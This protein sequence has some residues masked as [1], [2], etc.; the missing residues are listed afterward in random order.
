[1]NSYIPEPEIEPS[2][3]LNFMIKRW[4]EIFESDDPQIP[5]FLQA[6]AYAGLSTDEELTTQYTALF[7]SQQLPPLEVIRRSIEIFQ[8]ALRHDPDTKSSTLISEE[9][10]DPDVK[11]SRQVLLL[12]LY[13]GKIM[14][15][16]EDYRFHRVFEMLGWI[17]LQWDNEGL[18]AFDAVRTTYRNDPENL[19]RKGRDILRDR[20]ER[21]ISG[22]ARS[23]SE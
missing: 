12:T 23:E 4:N 15:E 21:G 13:E 16:Q 17:G 7:S 20:I 3:I 9:S 22:Q 1:M 5:S 18:S 14:I 2:V 19:V 8:T 11:T 6:L 10:R